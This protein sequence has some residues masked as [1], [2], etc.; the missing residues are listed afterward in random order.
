MPVWAFHSQGAKIGK[1]FTLVIQCFW[2]EV[3]HEVEVFPCL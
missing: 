1:E 3:E 2:G